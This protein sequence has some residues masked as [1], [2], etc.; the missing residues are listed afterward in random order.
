MLNLKFKQLLVLSDST[1]TANQFK[2]Q[3][4]WNL[5]TADD[6]SVG[7]STL[8]KLLF[9]SLGC[10][11]VLDET[12]KNLDCKTLLKFKVGSASY[13]VSRYKNTIRLKE[14]NS[15]FKKFDKITGD[16]S[17]RLAEILG[18]KVLLPSKSNG[19]LETPPP[20]Y[21]FLPYYIDQIRGWSDA[22]NSF[23][24][25]QQYGSWKSTVIKYHV[26]LL[27]PAYFNFEE[28]I[29]ENKEK[30]TEITGEI[31]RLN[32]TLEVV[33]AYVPTISGTISE[34]EFSKM[35][36]EIQNDLS[37]LIS[38]QEKALDQLSKY[39]SEKT[40]LEHQQRIAVDIIKQ[41]DDDYKFSV[42]N[43]DAD[44]VECPL[45][46][47]L[48]ENSVYNKASI[49]TDKNQAQQQLDTLDIS[50]STT[51]KKL[52]KV[53]KELDVIKSKIDEINSKYVIEEEGNFIALDDII[54]S[55]A[56]TAVQKNIENT[57]NGKLV[58]VNKVKED[59]KKIK[60]EQNKLQKN[61]KDYYNSINTTFTSLLIDYCDE[62]DAE[63]V[64]LS[65]V[66]TPTDYN[67]VFKGGGGAAENTRA[68]FAYYLTIYSLIE[69]FG[70]EVKSPLVI[71][72]PNQQ[73]QSKQNYDKIVGLI[74]NKISKDSQVI[75]CAMNNSQIE[76]YKKFANVIT[77]ETGERI[78]N[79]EMY[80]L[81]KQ[82]FI[83]VGK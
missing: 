51:A 18:F 67:K 48:H 6:N 36:G 53:K 55:F 42:E 37:E 29:S 14:K 81:V 59:Q 15:E 28:Q 38:R 71:D 64:N 52:V 41:L 5:I 39:E 45:C 70:N 56:S 82:E 8:V 44:E 24:N 49:L 75:L 1:S 32:T 63:A 19:K 78:L 22:W 54:N 16:Y 21:Y 10:D 83:G 30:V 50:L 69:K 7:K 4:H 46:G 26:G 34:S 74:T 47:V 62:L 12:W 13:Q 9:W 3:D 31:E 66:S 20:A 2:F 60:G 35:T 57:K 11:P 40:I 43:I 17:K 65:S 33:S 72:T 68:I 80:N 73:E 23:E 76:P 27:P 58:D 25:L 79:K 77:L 61:N